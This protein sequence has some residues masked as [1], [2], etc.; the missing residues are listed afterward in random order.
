[1]F[2]GAPEVEAALSGEARLYFTTWVLPLVDFLM[3]GESYFGESHDI[4][5]QHADRAG[6][7]RSRAQWLEWEE[8]RR[9]RT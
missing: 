8:Q 4:K 9:A 6:A 7:A 3:N 2:A 5:R 1:M